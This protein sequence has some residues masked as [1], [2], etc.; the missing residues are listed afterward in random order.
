MKTGA[1]GEALRTAQRRTAI[2]SSAD[3]RLELARVERAMGNRERAL[4][5]VKEILKDPDAPAEAKA[6]LNALS[7]ND[8]VAFRH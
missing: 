7:P 3:A 5:L 1:W 8:R 6:L 4:A 2:D